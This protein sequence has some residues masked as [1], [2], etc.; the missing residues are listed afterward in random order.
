LFKRHSRKRWF[1]L[2]S[3]SLTYYR[4]TTEYEAISV[5]PLHQI[6]SVT[7]NTKH[8]NCIRIWIGDHKK[9]DLV[10]DS[11]EDL[12]SWIEE[13]RKAT[14]EEGGLTTGLAGKPSFS[15]HRVKFTWEVAVITQYADS[16][17]QPVP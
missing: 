10:A 8:R 4:D 5:V 1:K 15:L 14:M 3:S 9:W 7:E 6:T 2:T 11:A 13:I 16:I 12:I 17:Y